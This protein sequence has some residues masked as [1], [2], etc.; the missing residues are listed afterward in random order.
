TAGEKIATFRARA[1]RPAEMLAAVRARQEYGLSTLQQ[2]TPSLK[3]DYNETLRI[4]E[5]IGP[6]VRD[7]KA[8][9]TSPTVGSRSEALKTFIAN[10]S[11]VVGLDA[12]EVA[13]LKTVADY[14]DPNGRLSFVELEQEV[15]GIPVFQGG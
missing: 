5:V 15:N 9:L 3:V 13:K 11:N 6:D 12:S 2:R 4:P 7:G 8:F 1:Q 14:T 10:N